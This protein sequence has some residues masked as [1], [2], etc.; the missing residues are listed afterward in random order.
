MPTSAVYSSTVSKVT[1]VTSY[2]VCL[3]FTNTTSKSCPRYYSIS[4]S[5]FFSLQTK[6]VA[7]VILPLILFQILVM[8]CRAVPVQWIYNWLG[9]NNKCCY[10]EILL[11]LVWHLDKWFVLMVFYTL[12]MRCSLKAKVIWDLC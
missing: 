7:D 4:F 2:I 8:L 1:F 10:W 9:E 11:T 3:L 5:F 6:F 12:S